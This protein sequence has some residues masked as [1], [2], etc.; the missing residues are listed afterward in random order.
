MP[1]NIKNQKEEKRATLLRAHGLPRTTRAI[2]VSYIHDAR[3]QAFLALA[4][5]SLGVVLLHEKNETILAGADAWITDVLDETIPISI[6]IGHV[7]VPIVPQ[8]DKRFVDFNPMKFEGN[9]F[10]FENINEY[11]MFASLVRYL[12][13]VRYAGDKHTL[14]KNLSQTQK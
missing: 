9:A 12:E 1:T 2:V 13:N 8:G 6:L 3:I 10:L 14:L 7:V 11:Q 4:C 5:D